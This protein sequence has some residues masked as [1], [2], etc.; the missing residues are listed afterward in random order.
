MA[1]KKAT[2]VATISPDYLD[3][4]GYYVLK[5]ELLW[6][7]RALDAEIR[8]LN[9]DAKI[10]SDELAAELDKHPE[11]KEL[12]SA[13]NAI[14]AETAVKMHDLALLNKKIEDVF[15]VN[16]KNCAI[17]DKTG[18]IHEFVDG[19][20]QAM[21]MPEPKSSKKVSTKKKK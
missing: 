11:I 12:I 14:T 8:N 10:R 20:P 17:D 2:A 5:G 9:M 3:D 15:K 21:R 1:K 7:Y 13:K 18:R 6:Q 19:A 4:E 16:L